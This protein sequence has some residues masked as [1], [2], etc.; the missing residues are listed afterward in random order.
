VFNKNHI[1]DPVNKFKYDAV[2][3]LIEAKGREH[4]TM[5]SCH[6][7]TK[8]K[9]HTEFIKITN[10]PTNNGQDIYNYAQTYKYDKNGNITK[11][12][13]VG[14]NGWT[15][16]QAYQDANNRLMTS[17]AGCLNE[18]TFD[19]LNNHDN[20]GNMQQMPHLHEM[21]WDYSNRLIEVE[22]NI[23]TNVSNDRAFYQYD[24]GGQRVR[25][26]IEQGDARVEVRIYIGGYEIYK[27]YNGIGTTFERSSLHVMDD[28]S[29]IALIEKKIKDIYDSDTG[30]VVR[31]RYQLDN[32]LGSSLH[33]V[34]E[35][36]KEINYEEYYPYGG[37]AYMA[38]KNETEVNLKRY[39]YSGKERDDE[40]GLYYYGARYYASW[41]GR[42][43]ICDPAGIV[44]GT[45]LYCFVKCNPLKLIDPNGCGARE[46]SLGAKLEQTTREIRDSASKN[47]NGGAQ[48]DYQEPVNYKDKKIIPDE[49]IHFRDPDNKQIKQI[50]ENKGR[51]LDSKWNS[52]KKARTKDIIAGLEQT[53]EQL[54]TLRE[55]GKAGKSTKARVFRV[56][57]DSDKG[58]SSRKNLKMWRQEAKEVRSAWINEAGDAAEKNLRKSIGITIGTF[59]RLSQV[60][61]LLRA[62]GKVAKYAAPG[63]ATVLAISAY[64]S[65]AAAEGHGFALM[66]LGTEVALDVIGT[67]GVGIT[68]AL[69][70]AG[71]GEE[72]TKLEM[73]RSLQL[74]YEGKQ[75]TPLEFS[76]LEDLPEANRKAEV[77]AYA[78]QTFGHTY[79]LNQA[80]P[81]F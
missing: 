30:S 64:S 20:N 57:F 17:K 80:N 81:V 48:V 23:Q 41:L 67:V 71:L 65:T 9:K 7:Q 39:R 18:S 37:T 34:D 40:T 21:N 2:Y 54:Q 69:S 79:F 62:G 58:V 14:N 50:V 10:Q 27:K 46:Q 11:I 74:M 36:A 59:D 28:K 45:N 53:K 61:N 24:T 31:T 22:T 5:T 26:V 55:A 73:I 47:I 13:H 44:D 33:E 19:Y 75:A 38:G 51:H 66:E 1:V 25:K 12:K 8:D 32:H 63:V 4:G 49:Q 70:P 29:R 52:S 56:M 77:E 16:D 78:M 72:M 60:K 43:V 42:W 68:A 6:Y 3:R 76:R 15:R 35:D